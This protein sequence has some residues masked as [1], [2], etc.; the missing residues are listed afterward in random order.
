VARDGCFLGIGEADRE[1]N[2]DSRGESLRVLPAPAGLVSR[3]SLSPDMSR[4]CRGR[5]AEAVGSELEDGVA[6]TF[7]G[8]M[9]VAT[10]MIVESL[11][12]HRALHLGYAKRSSYI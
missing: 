8:F 7:D 2:G 9:T 12:H 1:P 4:L 3:S 10:L 6:K 5:I 11:E